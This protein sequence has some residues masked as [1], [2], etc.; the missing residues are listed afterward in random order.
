VV[1]RTRLESGRTLTGTGSS[2]LPLS[3]I[4]IAQ[5]IGISLAVVKERIRENPLQL[6]LDLATPHFGLGNGGPDSRQRYWPSQPVGRVIE[7]IN[8]ILRGWV[9]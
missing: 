4:H 8:P 1:D 9:N 5:K 6:G 3:A 2:N 7:V